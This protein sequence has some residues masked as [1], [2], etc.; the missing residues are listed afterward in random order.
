MGSPVL[1]GT[2]GGRFREIGQLQHLDAL[3]QAIHLLQPERQDKC[4][5]GMVNLFLN[6]TG[7]ADASHL[8]TVFAR[9]NINKQKQITEK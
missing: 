3:G 9:L 2:S 7:D 5:S 1:S 4:E 6:A 8:N